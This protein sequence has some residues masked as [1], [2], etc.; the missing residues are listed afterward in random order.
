MSLTLRRGGIAA[1]TLALFLIAAPTA[2][3]AHVGVSPDRIPAGQVTPLTFSFSHGCGESP[4]TSLR[5]TMPKGIGSA[6]PAFDGDWAADIEKDAGGAITAVTFTA[7]QPVPVDLR[8]SVELAVI[9]DKNAA[10]ELVFPVEQ[11]CVAGTNEWTQVAK[12]GEN[13]HDL[14]SP[15]PVVALTAAGASGEHGQQGMHGDEHTVAPEASSSSTEKPAAILP[16]LLGGGGLVI[17]V[18]ALLVAVRAYRRRA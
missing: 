9:T 8:G 12:D 18:A 10:D 7:A 16:M 6:W 5:V 4:T 3:S 14:D 11:R 1:A 17:A 15:A 2:A 13:A